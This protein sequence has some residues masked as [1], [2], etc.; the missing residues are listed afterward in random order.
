MEQEFPHR[1]PKPVQISHARVVKGRGRGKEIG[2]PTI[3]VETSAVPTDLPRG[4]YA[5]RITMNR[6]SFPGALHYGPRPAFNDTET[7]EIHV[8]DEDV[9]SVPQTVDL[10][11][12]RYIRPVQDY[13]NLE[14]LLNA[15]KR[16]ID[17]ARGILADA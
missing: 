17:A 14:D 10:E 6:K 4:I 13:Q 1:P 15:I 12:I 7:M 9:K 3:N 8:I 11:L 5:C 16:D 2:V